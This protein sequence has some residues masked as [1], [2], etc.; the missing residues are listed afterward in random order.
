MKIDIVSFDNAFIE[1]LCSF[2]WFDHDRLTDMMKRYP[3][4]ATESQEPIFWH[5]DA[6]HRITN[7]HIITMSGDTGEVY[8]RSWFYQDG[9]KTCLF[10]EHLL[11]EYPTHSVALVKDEITAAVMSCFPTPYVWLATGKD[12]VA[13]SDLATLKGRKMIVFPDKGEY[14]RWQDTMRTASDL[15]CHISDAMEKTQGAAISISQVM[16]S[17]QRLRPTEEEAALMRLTD[18]NPYLTLFVDGLGLEVV[19]VTKCGQP[20]TE[21]VPTVEG[22]K[23]DAEALAKAKK[24]AE[25]F[26]LEQERRW[27]GMNPDCHHCSLSHESING[28]YCNKL[29]R[30]VEHGK[31]DCGIDSEACGSEGKAQQLG[32]TE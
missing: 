25:A 5:I 14:G 28:T 9:R 6:D 18:A 31:A 1:Y 20:M 23:P 19:S 3:I 22:S 11:K 13:P 30:Y 7:G 21:K 24:E 17:Q 32:I 15:S 26:K 2:E 27:H 8:G 12:V 29:R 10:G 4:G 16:L